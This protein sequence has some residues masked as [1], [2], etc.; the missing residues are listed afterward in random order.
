[1]ADYA[2]L[3]ELSKGLSGGDILNVCVNAIHAGS[4]DPNPERWRLTQEMLEREIA[5]VKKAKEEH[6]G[7]KWNEKRVIGFQPS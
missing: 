6:S 7:E 4:V 5:K 1:M 3:A 2:V